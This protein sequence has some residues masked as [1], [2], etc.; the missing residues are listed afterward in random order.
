MKTVCPHCHQEFPETPDEY[1]DQTLQ[2]PSC[3]GEFVAA[4]SDRPRV[5]PAI[6]VPSAEPVGAPSGVPPRRTIRISSAGSMSGTDRNAIQLMGVTVILVICAMLLGGTAV[7]FSP[8]QLDYKVPALAAAIA[9]AVFAVLT[10]PGLT[11]IFRLPKPERLIRLTPYRKFSFFLC[12][13]FATLFLLGTLPV[14]FTKFGKQG[15]AGFCIGVLFLGYGLFT[16][17]H[18]LKVRAREDGGDESGEE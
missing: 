14:A 5:R 4:D 12:M 13:L 2:C 10:F 1:R 8:K 15:G 17:W 3:G 7:Y 11:L 6:V 16:T 18:W 9:G